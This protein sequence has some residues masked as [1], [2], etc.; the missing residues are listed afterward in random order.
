MLAVVNHLP[1]ETIELFELIETD[2]IELIWRGCVDAPENKYFN[3]I[4]LKKDG[5]FY[6]T[7]MF[8]SNISELLIGA[9]KSFSFKNR[10]N[11]GP[12]A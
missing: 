1:R 3:D 4:A 11:T 8:D 12:G 9:D 10:L 6:A 2:A 7:S 5:S